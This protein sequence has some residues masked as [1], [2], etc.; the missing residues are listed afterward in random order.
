MTVKK[1]DKSPD[2][3]GLESFG[4]SEN[5][6]AVYLYLLARGVE[7]GGS[8]IAIGIKLHRQYIYLALPKLISLGLVEEVAHGK[9]SKYK[10]KP[11]IQLEKIAK[12]K[13]LEAG[14]LAEQLKKISKVGYEQDFEVV[15]GIPAIQQYE[16]DRIT[17]VPEDTEQYFI[18]GASQGFFDMMAGEYEREYAPIANQKKLKSYY[19]G[20]KDEYKVAENAQVLDR[21]HFEFRWL[22]TFPKG[23]VNIMIMNDTV[24]FYTFV[25]PPILYV[26]TSKIVA[27]NLKRFFMML[28]NIAAKN[29]SLS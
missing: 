1:Q 23:V 21:Q 7:V 20:Y 25:N 28:W 19:I 4:L 29:T 9:Q 8:K 11:P 26:V 5:E 22:P 14:E 16:I 17:S 24:S 2:L 10:A 12:R 27:E 3:L 6:A 15:Q 13:A 18:G